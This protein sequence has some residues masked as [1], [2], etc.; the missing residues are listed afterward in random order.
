M[1][2]TRVQLGSADYFGSAIKENTVAGIRMLENVYAPERYMPRHAHENASISFLL[3]G[4]CDDSLERKQ[5]YCCPSTL[6]FHP[7]GE[8]HASR[9]HRAGGRLF[10]IDLSIPWVK[11]IREHAPVLD[12]PAVITGTQLAV[13]AWRLY[14]EFRAADEVSGLA[15][16]G[17]LLEILA[18]AARSEAKQ[19]RGKIPP[20][21]DRARELIRCRFAERLSLEGIAQE[22]GRHP[23]HLARSFR[24]H[25]GS[26]LGEFQRQVRVEFAMQQLARTKTP[27]SEI[28]LTAGFS[29]QSHFCNTFR[30]YS[31]M[32]PVQFRATTTTKKL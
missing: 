32:N 19:R 31:G 17:L 14:Q 15:I 1:G 21:V 2:N 18:G 25:C 29:D 22:V 6:I 7:A 26:T 27:L 9:Y 12:T 23:V 28:A 24:E 4:Y 16:E 20:W 30:R 10:V 3:Q 13:L 11:R 8:S 5:R